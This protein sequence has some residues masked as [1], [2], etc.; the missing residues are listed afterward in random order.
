MTGAWREKS[1]DWG[2]GVIHGYNWYKAL[3]RGED[4]ENVTIQGPGAIDG[5]NVFNPDGEERMRGPHGMSIDNC[6]NLSIRNLAIKN[7]SNWNLRLDNCR[8]V[9]VDGYTATG[10]WDG[11]N[12]TK[13]TDITI[14]NCRLYA[15]DDAVAG[16]AKN[17][18]MTNC[19][20]SSGA[21]GFR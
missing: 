3:V 8:G 14:S 16:S 19:L 1:V 9:N 20:L 4:I 11:I 2:Y 7:G 18:T 15:G 13:V 21:N 5:N 10:G 6:R 12:L 17:M